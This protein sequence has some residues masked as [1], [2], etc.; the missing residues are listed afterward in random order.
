[1]KRSEQKRLG[2]T[3][4][5]WEAHSLVTKAIK[6]GVLIPSSNCEDCGV[7]AKTIAHHDDYSK[8]LKVRWVCSGCHA[9]IHNDGS[10]QKVKP[11]PYRNLDW[12]LILRFGVYDL[13]SNGVGLASQ[14]SG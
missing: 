3:D 13:L 11:Y 10:K 6:D 2:E 9:S 4:S 12:R 7:A 14:S 8:P 1:M 5:H